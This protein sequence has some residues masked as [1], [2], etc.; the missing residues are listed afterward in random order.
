MEEDWDIY[1]SRESGPRTPEQ[2]TVDYDLVTPQIVYDGIAA[3]ELVAFSIDDKS[4]VSLTDFFVWVTNRVERGQLFEIEL[5]DGRHVC[6]TD[7]RGLPGCPLV[8]PLKA[9]WQKRLSHL[10]RW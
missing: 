6:M 7:P 10:H 9:E 8:N 1:R 2:L 3:G 4:Y 5:P